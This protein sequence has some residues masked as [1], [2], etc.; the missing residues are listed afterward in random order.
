MGRDKE[1]WRVNFIAYLSD[2]VRNSMQ[3]VQKV[4]E[5]NLGIKV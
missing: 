4:C 2:V 3:K 5:V 1:E